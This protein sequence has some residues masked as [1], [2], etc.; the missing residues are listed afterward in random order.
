[1]KVFTSAIRIKSGAKTEEVNITNQVEA[2][3]LE[4]N[5][6]EGMALVFTGHTTASIHLNNADRD[7]EEDFHNF[8]KELIPNKPTY[9]H[10]KGDYGRNADAHL[11]SLLVGNSITIPITKGRL[12]LGQWQ[13]IYFSEFDGPRS[14]LISIKIFGSPESSER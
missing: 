3:I 13:G 5:I 11:K 8:L 9:R 12:A 7:L 6:Y 4:S 14:R 10:N 1:M 2:V